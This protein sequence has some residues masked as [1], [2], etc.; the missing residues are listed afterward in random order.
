MAYLRRGWS[1]DTK[2]LFPL[3]PKQKAP[4]KNKIK[5]NYKHYSRVINLS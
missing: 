4:Q 1:K 5:N 2:P 3:K